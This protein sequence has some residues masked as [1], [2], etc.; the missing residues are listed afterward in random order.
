VNMKSLNTLMVICLLVIAGESHADGAYTDA[1]ALLEDA[2]RQDSVS[3][4]MGGEIAD[5]FSSQ[6]STK[7]LL[8]VEARVI[9]S[10]KE[11]GCKRIGLRFT[12]EG[13]ATPKG[14]T[15]VHL[16]MTINYCLNGDIPNPAE[17]I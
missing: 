14:N 10:F 9:G 11:E 1:K 4:V 3:G 8:L 12:Q 5:A 16:N 6:F 15:E 2:I 7:G 17:Q 13:V